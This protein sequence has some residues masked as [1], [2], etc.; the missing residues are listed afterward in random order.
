MTEREG[1]ASH[2]PEEIERMLRAWSEER[3]ADID[4]YVRV[5]LM[6]KQGAKQVAIA[7]SIGRSNETVRQKLDKINRI[8]LHQNYIEITQAKAETAYDC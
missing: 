4:L 6:F 8:L 2:S 1:I 5:A 7:K 3:L